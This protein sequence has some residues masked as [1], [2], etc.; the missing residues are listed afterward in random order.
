LPLSIDAF[1][2]DEPVV[3]DEVFAF[4][5]LFCEVVFDCAKR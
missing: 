3:V 2:F 5:L 1:K 4:V